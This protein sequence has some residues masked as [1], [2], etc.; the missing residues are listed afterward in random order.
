MVLDFF[1]LENIGMVLSDYYHVLEDWKK[2]FAPKSMDKEWDDR[3]VEALDKI[4][5]LEQVMDQFLAADK[6]ER[7]DHSL[8]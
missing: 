3:F 4:P 1:H 2:A 6:D 7:K 5:F 8:V